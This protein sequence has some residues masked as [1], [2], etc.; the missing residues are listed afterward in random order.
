MTTDYEVAGTRYD[1]GTI[2]ITLLQPLGAS[3]STFANVSVTCA[4]NA[5]AVVGL[6]STAY[7][8]AALSGVDVACE[9]HIWTVKTC[10]QNVAPSLCVDCADPCSPTASCLDAASTGTPTTPQALVSPFTV[11]ACGVTPACS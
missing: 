7:T 5:S 8:A 10:S 6:M 4:A 11:A 1:V 3:L 9:G 2:S